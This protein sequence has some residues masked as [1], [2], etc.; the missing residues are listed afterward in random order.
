MKDD[1][2]NTNNTQNYDKY[3]VDNTPIMGEGYYATP[4]GKDP[5]KGQEFGQIKYTPQGTKDT[6]Y[7]D[8]TRDTDNDRRAQ[9]RG[10]TEV[11]RNIAIKDEDN[12]QG[13]MY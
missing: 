4:L 10:N 9:I 1:S 6:I 7:D 12:S 5:S 2:I 11:G 13:G 8:S 3:V